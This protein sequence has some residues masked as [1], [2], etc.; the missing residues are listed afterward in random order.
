M[1]EDLHKQAN[2]LAWSYRRYFDKM[3]DRGFT[4]GQ[5]AITS[6]M[7]SVSQ[8]NIVKGVGAGIAVLTACL[9]SIM[10]QDEID[11]TKISGYYDKQN[12]KEITFEVD[13]NWLDS[14]D[15]EDSTDNVIH[16]DFKDKD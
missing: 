9:N 5:I 3:I 12:E 14:D 10:E 1:S 4:P 16:V 2:E 7:L 8:Y 15:N 11:I 6:I 13:G